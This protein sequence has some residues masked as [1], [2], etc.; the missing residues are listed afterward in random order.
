[1]DATKAQLKAKIT[2]AEGLRVKNEQK[3]VWD[4]AEAAEYEKLLGEADKLKLMIGLNDHAD[5]LKAW[6][7]ESA[8]SFVRDGWRNAGPTEGV[9]SDVAAHAG[10]DGSDLYALGTVGAAKMAVL[11]SG[12]YKD[13]FVDYMRSMAKYGRMDAVKAESM[14]V[15]Q[16]GVDTAGG[17]WVP[18]DIR[19]DVVKKIATIAAIRPNAY[20]FT[21]GSDLVTF[22]K[23]VYTADDKYTSGVRFGWTAEAPAAAISEATNPVAGRVTIP[24][25]T[26]T[27]AIIL[28][29]ALMEDSQFDLL[30]YCTML[31]G[32][33]FGLGEDD[34]FISGDG[35]GKPQGFT[36]HANASVAHASGGMYVISG[37]NGAVSWGLSGTAATT[38]GTIGITGMEAALP[39][40]YESNAKWYANKA[41]YA[42][43]RALTD[44]QNR[45]LW[46]TADAW[47]STANGMAAN[48]LGYAIVKDQFMP[49]L[50]TDSL[51]VA[52]GD[53]GGYYVADRVGLSVEVLRELRA[54][55]D[56]VI[57]YARKRVGG[58]LVHDWKLKLLKAGTS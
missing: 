27:A 10:S 13:A 33:A 46:M 49:A 35:V 25:H 9:I 30:G 53:M 55:Q 26:A 4:E 34:A 39:P 24:V 14:K 54:L 38:V 1:M 23:V 12:A 6:S 20:A 11:K 17:F 32:E 36:K 15:L 37:T 41:T 56:E 28:T 22:P 18:P 42:M 50:A 44:T 2:Q 43:I 40:Q 57:I 21:T 48:L 3:G 5:E 19:A 58:Q 31:L 45:P 16:E 52:H 7:H 8:G 47:P 29:R 51:S